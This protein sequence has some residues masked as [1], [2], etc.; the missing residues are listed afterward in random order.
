MPR[1]TWGS[2]LNDEHLWR[3]LRAPS[4]PRDLLGPANERWCKML[5]NAKATACFS[6]IGS[7]TVEQVVLR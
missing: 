3:I 5:R 6:R 4:E 2:W 7:I 1:K